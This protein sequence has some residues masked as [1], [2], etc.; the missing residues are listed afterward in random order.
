MKI[1]YKVETSGSLA[2]VTAQYRVGRGRWYAASTF[3]LG[4]GTFTLGESAPASLLCF[5]ATQ[6]LREAAGGPQHV[7]YEM[8]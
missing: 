7:L 3:R 8:I 5:H 2:S 1:C 4:V 6:L